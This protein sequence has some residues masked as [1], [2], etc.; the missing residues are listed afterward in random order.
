[1]TLKGLA[2]SKWRIKFHPNF[3]I[4]HLRRRRHR[5]PESK[6]E[7]LQSQLCLSGDLVKPV[8]IHFQEKKTIKVLSD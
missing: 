8:A 6:I 2:V 3:P 5:S 4:K 1:M 7:F